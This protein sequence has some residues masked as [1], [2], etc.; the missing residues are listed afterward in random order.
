MKDFH[1]SPWFLVIAGCALFFLGYIAAED[2]C[3][4]R[5]NK[6]DMQCQMAQRT[7]KSSTTN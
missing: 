4:K 1:K 7:L 5:L 2:E 6:K 3:I